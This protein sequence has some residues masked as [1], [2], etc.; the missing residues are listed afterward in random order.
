MCLLYSWPWILEHGLWNLKEEL[1]GESSNGML[2]RLVV[3][4]L[5]LERSGVSSAAIRGT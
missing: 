3:R 5:R 4:A 2:T 1:K